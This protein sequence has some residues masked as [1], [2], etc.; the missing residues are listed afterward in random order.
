MKLPCGCEKS[1]VR[2]TVLV[3]LLRLGW[4]GLFDSL[5]GSVEVK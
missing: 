2:G 1:K 3:A 5:H 4:V